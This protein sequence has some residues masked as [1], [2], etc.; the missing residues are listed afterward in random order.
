MAHLLREGEVPYRAWKKP[1]TLILSRK[2]K[3]KRRAGKITSTT[4]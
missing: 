2:E 1:L 4:D 3:G